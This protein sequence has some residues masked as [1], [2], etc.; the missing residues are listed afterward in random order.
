LPS[1]VSEGPGTWTSFGKKMG[2]MRFFVI[3]HIDTGED[4]GVLEGGEMLLVGGGDVRGGCL[5]GGRGG[6][7]EVRDVFCGCAIAHGA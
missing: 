7:T 5:S 2:F 3:E 4:G 1:S 6:L